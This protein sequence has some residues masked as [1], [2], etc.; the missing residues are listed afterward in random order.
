MLVPRSAGFKN[1]LY[2]HGIEETITQINSVILDT[3][4]SDLTFVLAE[5]MLT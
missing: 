3:M 2:R 5:V 1:A 4:F